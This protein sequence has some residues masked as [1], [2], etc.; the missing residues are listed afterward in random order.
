MVEYRESHKMANGIKQRILELNNRGNNKKTIH[1]RVLLAD[2][3]SGVRFH[4]AGEN[5]PV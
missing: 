2:L 3:T 5:K 1:I 4:A